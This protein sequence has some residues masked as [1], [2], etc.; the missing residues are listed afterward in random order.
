MIVDGIGHDAAEV[1][2]H[3]Q[4]IENGDPALRAKHERVAVHL[5]APKTVAE[6]D[7]GVERYEVEAV[8]GGK[9][10]G[11]VDLAV[12]GLWEARALE[13]RRLVRVIER[14]LQ[15]GAH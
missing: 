8:A 9:P 15:L 11:D 3:D 7:E 2:G 12:A 1:C 13:A 6:L 14:Q 4:T 5:F 10:Y